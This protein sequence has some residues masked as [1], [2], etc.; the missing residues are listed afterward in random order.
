MKNIIRQNITTLNQLDII[1]CHSSNWER[2]QL[3]NQCRLLL[4]HIDDAPNPQVLNELV[5]EILENADTLI[6]KWDK[7]P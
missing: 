4:E 2:D 6:A 3:V 1:N 5:K 7:K